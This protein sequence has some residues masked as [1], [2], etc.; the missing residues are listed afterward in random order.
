MAR[1]L[2][3]SE[4]L[5]ARRPLLQSTYAVVL[6]GGRGTRLRQLTDADA[7]PAVPFGGHLRIIDFTLSNCINSGLRRIDVL[8]QY[9][10]QSLIR[11]IMHGWDFLDSTLDEFIDVVPAQQQLG[12][13]WYCGTANAV[14]QN[15]Q[16]LRDAQ[17]QRVLVLAGDHVYKMDYGRMLAAHVERNADVSVA[18]IEVPLGEA[19]A[20]GV[21]QLDDDGRITA[22]EEKPAL[23]QPRPGCTE[24]ALA[25]M[26]IY[27]F[28][29]DV[30]YAALESD[31]ANAASGHDFGHDIVPQLLA[32]SRVFAHDFAQSCVNLVG[33]RPYW[34]DVG[35]L[36][37]YWEANMD[38]THTVPE[39]NLYD[40]AWPIRTQE[41]HLPPA[42]FVFDDEGRRGQAIDSLVASGC[43]VSGATVRRSLLFSK[44]RVDDGSVVEDALL[45]PHAVV[46]RRVVLR[47]VIV[48]ERCV[49]PDDT[50]IGVD[51]EA[52]RARYT[53]TDKGVTLVTR[54]MLGQARCRP[55]S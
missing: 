40:D 42:K 31:A 9:K 1:P 41:Q 19:S 51:A 45:L 32:R 47:R 36:D 46:G 53:V 48:G 35:T 26:G 20:F 23:P 11:H 39:L 16:M 17:P 29:A 27:L 21:M 7:K 49:L 12:A 3:L 28:N 14:F 2:A 25:S 52:D 18:S 10:S 24:V 34:R 22:F 38:L 43:I 55:A 8:T 54:E 30:L 15:L 13:G 4:P 37:A 44:V 6:A 5:A 50:R 33:D